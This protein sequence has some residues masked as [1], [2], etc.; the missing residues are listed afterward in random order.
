MKKDEKRSAQRPKASRGGALYFSA[1][2]FN[3]RLQT[4]RPQKSYHPHRRNTSFLSSLSSFLH[5]VSRPVYARGGKKLHEA[6]QHRANNSRPFTL[7]VAISPKSI[8]FVE[9]KKQTPPFRM[10][11]V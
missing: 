4:S 3:D 10:E 8:S 5:Y 2:S 1:K 9:T 7:F 11:P 6:E